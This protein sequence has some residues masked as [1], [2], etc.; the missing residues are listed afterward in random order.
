MTTKKNQIENTEEKKIKIEKHEHKQNDDV[1]DEN[2]NGE[3]N[4]KPYAYASE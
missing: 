4:N 1:H 2:D 3:N